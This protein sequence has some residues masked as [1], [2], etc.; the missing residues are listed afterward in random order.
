MQLLPASGTATNPP[1]GLYTLTLKA[2]QIVTGKDY[3]VR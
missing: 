3:G 1:G 2:G